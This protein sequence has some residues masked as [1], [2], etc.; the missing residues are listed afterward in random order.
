MLVIMNNCGRCGESTLSLLIS[1][2]E[3]L[4]KAKDLLSKVWHDIGPYNREHVSEGDIV[5][6]V[7]SIDTIVRG[8]IDKV[9]E[10]LV[11][12]QTASKSADAAKGIGFF[13]GKAMDEQQIAIEEIV[14]SISNM[15]DYTQQNAAGAEQLSSSAENLSNGAES[16]KK[17]IEFFKVTQ[18]LIK[19]VGE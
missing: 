12:A 16:L 11:Y 5:E 19:R 8:I 15:N 4:E 7:K 13:I 1:E 14:K 3:S 10:Q 18:N 2:I 9:Q 17:S 6:D